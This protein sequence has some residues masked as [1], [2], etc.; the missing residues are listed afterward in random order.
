MS[1]VVLA[2]LL[3]LAVFASV[4]RASGKDVIRDCTDDEV[5]AKTYTQKEYKDAL[6]QLGSDSD[7]YGDCRDIIKSA[8]LKA[9][10]DAHKKRAPT[11]NGGAGG[12]GSGAGG[13]GGGTSSGGG[14][15][16]P[17][18]AKQLQSATPDERSAVDVGRKA[19]RTAINV[20]GAAVK[21][22]LGSSSDLPAPLLVLLA[23]VLAGA[24]ALA[25]IRIRTLVLA[26]RA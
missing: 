12:G 14:Y 2:A 1:F 7:Q 13:G 3:S 16:S 22:G 18:A 10:R 19:A 20:Q 15:G 11:T 4:A 6:A 24:L 23:L 26:R 17:P 8:Q 9:L 5:L 25:A 21:P